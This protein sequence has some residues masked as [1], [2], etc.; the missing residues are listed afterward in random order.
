[1]PKSKKILKKIGKFWEK[2]LAK[3]ITAPIIDIVLIALFFSY[4][5][6][7]VRQEIFY[8]FVVFPLNEKLSHKGW[9]HEWFQPFL[10]RL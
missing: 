2:V 9:N 5:L 4:I 3:A 10:L 7:L 8:K 1:L 6:A